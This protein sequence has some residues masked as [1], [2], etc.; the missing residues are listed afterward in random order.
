M[1]LFFRT[2][3]EE[4]PAVIILHG[5]FGIS[6]NWVTFG[7]KLADRGFKVYIPDLRNHGQSPH[8]STFN[9]LALT[10]DLYDFIDEHE[11]QDPI[12]IGHS[13]GGKTTSRFALENQEI[14]KKVIVVDISLRAY[15][16]R[17]N[18][19]KIIDG[20]RRIDFDMA[21]SRKQVD[22]LLSERI[23]DLRIR[24]FILKNLYWKDKDRLDWRINFEAICDNLEDMFDG[25]DTIDR[26]NKPA[27]FIKGGL[28]DYI[29]PE[30]FPTI[31]YNF[32]QSKIITIEN[33][34]H[35]V[36]AE[37]PEEFAKLVFDFL[38]ED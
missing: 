11:I 13:M 12:I 18:H 8:S 5:L 19:A 31:K 38:K 2:Y 17:S 23:P 32:P 27:L 22:M 1:K 9:Y 21:K 7:K 30:D 16:S 15:A 28:S 14:V 25:I 20:M 33:T 34:S 35:W 4:D 26:F 36:H 6:D 3:G 10:D 24:Q 29:L 37:A